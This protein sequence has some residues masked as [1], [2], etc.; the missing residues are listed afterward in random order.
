MRKF[1]FA[2]ALTLTLFAVGCVSPA[3]I[4][5][6]DRGIAANKGHMNDE[7]LP[8]EAREIGQDNY[9][10]G[11]QLKFNL[12]GT[13]LPEDTAARAQA[14]ADAKAAVEAPSDDVPA[15]GGDE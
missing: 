5:A 8:Q 15:E 13:E 7:S 3:A 10:W 14:R 12:C 2:S 9:D 4:T 1:L 6:L 11:N